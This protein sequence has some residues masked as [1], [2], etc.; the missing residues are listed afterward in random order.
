MPVRGESCKW[1][2]AN[3]QVLLKA[4]ERDTV[5]VS[6][7]ILMLARGMADLHILNHPILETFDTVQDLRSSGLSFVRVHIY[8]FAVSLF[9][10]I[11]PKIVRKVHECVPADESV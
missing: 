6:W 7:R 8:L 2:A 3:V 11:L 5:T 10:D 1:Q 9:D 4:R